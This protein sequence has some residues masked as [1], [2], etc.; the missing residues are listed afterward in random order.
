M[1]EERPTQYFVA[2][3]TSH[4]QQVLCTYP[5]LEGSM[6]TC[7]WAESLESAFLLCIRLPISSHLITPTGCPHALLGQ[8]IPSPLK[9]RALEGEGSRNRWH[10]KLD[11]EQDGQPFVHHVSDADTVDCHLHISGCVR[12]VHSRLSSAVRVLKQQCSNRR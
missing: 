9:M 2:L 7:L 11:E 10:Q 4:T 8:D 12:P 3:H 6:E 5:G 1:E